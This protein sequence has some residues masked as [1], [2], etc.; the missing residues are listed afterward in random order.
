MR[1]IAFFLFSLL[2][3]S[4]SEGGEPSGSIVM[5]CA[6]SANQ[7]ICDLTHDGAMCGIQRADAT[8]SLILQKHYKDVE[9]SYLALKELDTYKACLHNSVAAKSRRNKSDEISRYETISRISHFQDKLVNETRGVR[10]EINLW[11]YKRNGDPDKWESML[12]GVK[13]ASKVHPDVYLAM[14]ANAAMGS[15]DK[16]KGIA[17]ELK[18]K[19]RYLNSMPPEL[20]EFYITYYLQEG[21]PFK[22]AVWQ[23][24]YAHYLKQNSGINE[25]YFKRYEK[26]SA[27][28]LG[29]AKGLVSRI[30]FTSSWAELE[31]TDLPLTII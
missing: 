4:C 1:H 15:I 7:D 17:D 5:L 10:P 20:Y 3:F 12:N 2:L 26:M 6:D 16:A 8:R 28:R 21:Q 23:G 30:L 13:V 27:V 29:E 25:E 22:S 9:H 31:Y 19:S 18:V 11:L 24:L 14:M